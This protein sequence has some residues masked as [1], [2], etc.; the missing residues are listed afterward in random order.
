MTGIFYTSVKL[1]LF[2][3]EHKWSTWCKQGIVEIALL[4][5]LDVLV[6]ITAAATNTAGKHSN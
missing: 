3:L 4:L 2:A 5:I 1:I 6:S